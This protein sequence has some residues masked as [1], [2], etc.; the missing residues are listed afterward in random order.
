MFRDLLLE[1][2]FERGPR[3]VRPKAGRSG[4][5]FL[6]R[7]AHFIRRA[8]IPRVFLCDPL[9]HRLHALEPAS[10]IEIRAL[11]AGVQL[12]AALGTLFV[13]GHPLQYGSALRTPRYRP[14]PRQIHGP[15]TQCMVPLRWTAL[16]LRGRLSR[17][18][19]ARLAITVL[20]S[21][22]TIFRHSTLP[23]TRSY[24]VPGSPG[25]QVRTI[26][27]PS[28]QIITDFHGSNNKFLFSSLS[29]RILA[30]PRQTVS[31]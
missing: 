3:I 31:P 23:T 16:A 22:L 10:R 5:L 17:L 11:L 26:G 15:R 29:V 1:Q 27:N 7:N 28:P 12:K 4:C 25:R 2:I 20:I 8:R 9:L 24:S 19:P 18:L 21:R 30:N 13:T 6:P 14:R